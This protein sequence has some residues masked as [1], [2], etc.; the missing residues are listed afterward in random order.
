MEEKKPVPQ[1]KTFDPA[2]PAYRFRLWIRRKTKD[3]IHVHVYWRR[4]FVSLI[5]LM[6]VGWFALALAAMAFIRV[7]RGI[8][9]V[10]YVDLAFPWRSRCP[11]HH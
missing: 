3:G 6:I 9:E 2:N 1:K 5:A 4:I 8:A 7:N 10:Q 11:S